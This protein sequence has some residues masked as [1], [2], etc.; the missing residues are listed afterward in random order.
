MACS[1]IGGTSFAG[2]KISTISMV[3]WISGGI[4]SRLVITFF[5]KNLISKRVYW[6]DAVAMLF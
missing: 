3:F 1:T 6:Y 5:A 4:S 2:L